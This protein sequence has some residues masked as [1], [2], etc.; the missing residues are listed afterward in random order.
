MLHMKLVFYERQ[1]TPSLNFCS[2]SSK[3]IPEAMQQ[4]WDNTSVDA[5]F[6]LPDELMWPYL[7]VPTYLMGLFVE[8]FNFSWV[9]ERWNL[10]SMSLLLNLLLKSI[11]ENM[12]L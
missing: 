9:D 10:S 5:C 8:F 7:A 11:E 4:I 12:I 6:D 1:H 3:A 2:S